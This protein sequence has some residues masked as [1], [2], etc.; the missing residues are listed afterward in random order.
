MPIDPDLLKVMHKNTVKKK[1]IKEILINLGW[2]Y[3]E[4]YAYIIFNHDLFPNL[5]LKTGWGD[6]LKIEFTN[7]D[8]SYMW[9]DPL[10]SGLDNVTNEEIVDAITY[11]RFDSLL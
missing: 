11:T 9:E 3:T 5:I 6:A 1:K 4:T 2:K 8:E 7:T 10:E